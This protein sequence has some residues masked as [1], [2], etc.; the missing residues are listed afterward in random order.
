MNLFLYKT[1]F[2]HGYHCTPLPRS[3]STPVLGKLHPSASSFYCQDGGGG[4]YKCFCLNMHS[5]TRQLS[6]LSFPLLVG[7]W[8]KKI[9]PHSSPLSISTFSILASGGKKYLSTILSAF[10][11]HFL[12]VSWWK[13]IYPSTFFIPSSYPHFLFHLSKHFFIIIHFSLTGGR[14][15]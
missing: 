6:T 7:G 13:R 3:A 4:V 11:I 10:H 5:T 14:E 8:E 1:A 2:C 15:I 9:N 12:F